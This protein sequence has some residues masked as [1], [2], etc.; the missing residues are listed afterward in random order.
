MDPIAANR[1]NWDDRAEIHLRNSTGFYGIE[2]V[3]AGDKLL[4]P[5]VDA[6]LGDVAGLRVA[7]LQCHFGLDT[8]RLARRGAIATGLDFSP[9]A[10]A[11]ARALA[12]ELGEA[13]RFVEGDVHEARSLLEG[14]FD[15]V[16]VTW[17]AI[18]WLPDMARWARVVAALLAPGG[19]LYLA[20]SH[21][22]MNALEQ[23]GG[24]LILQRP[25]RVPIGS[26]FAYDDETTYTGAPDRLA[27]RQSYEWA[28]PFSAILGGLLAAGFRLDFL[29]EHESLPWPAFPMM[30]PAGEGMFRLPASVPAMPLA[31]SLRATLS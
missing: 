18:C 31:F 4:D 13:V 11:G 14:Q 9:R 7:H 19:A 10:I 2:A 6:E 20:D 16:Y 12:S 24:R 22:A 15:L 25:W 3:R 5:I 26:P 23:E 8:I 28:H 1:L 30:E 27:H 21:P 29:H 17:G